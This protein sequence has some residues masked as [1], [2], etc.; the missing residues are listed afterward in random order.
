MQILVTKYHAINQSQIIFLGREPMVVIVGSLR[1]HMQDKIRGMLLYTLSSFST[2]INCLLIAICVCKTVNIVEVVN[3]PILYVFAILTHFIVY[4]ELDQYINS[5]FISFNNI[6][7]HAQF[8]LFYT[9][10]FQ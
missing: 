7:K 4:M 2:S 3:P 10:N 8:F 1:I 5:F 6:L 9:K